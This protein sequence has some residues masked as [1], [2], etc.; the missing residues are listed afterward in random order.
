MTN[1]TKEH[2]LEIINKFEPCLENKKEGAL[3][4][5]GKQAGIAF[6][7][8]RQLFNAYE[9]IASICRI[10]SHRILSGCTEYAVQYLVK[11]LLFAEEPK[12]KWLLF[13]RLV[14]KGTYHEAAQQS[15]KVSW[16]QM[17]L[18]LCFWKIQ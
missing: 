10:Y 11:C 2:C 17:C 14:F 9:N 6:I 3:G 16:S 1:V 15:L 7:G 5:D 12:G 13:E 4:I 8:K 18:Y